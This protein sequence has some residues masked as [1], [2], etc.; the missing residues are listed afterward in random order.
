M[1]PQD[2]VYT[3]R[4]GCRVRAIAASEYHERRLEACAKHAGLMRGFRRDVLAEMARR[5][6]EDWDL[7]GRP[8]LA[9][10]LDRAEE[11]LTA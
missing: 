7:A 11:C 2:F 9:L 10:A 4:C 1:D 6:F 3:A 8:T 5:A